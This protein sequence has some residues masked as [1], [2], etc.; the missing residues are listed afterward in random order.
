MPSDCIAITNY[1][2]A[3]IEIITVQS[4]DQQRILVIKPKDTHVVF[5][6]RVEVIGWGKKKK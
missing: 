5:T 2:S 1:T 3:D 4:D 6:D